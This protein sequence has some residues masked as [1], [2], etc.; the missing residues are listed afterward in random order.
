[1]FSCDAINQTDKC[2]GRNSRYYKIIFILGPTLTFVKV[3]IVSFFYP[4][5]YNFLV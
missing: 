4:N 2:L 1:M 5:Q 3:G